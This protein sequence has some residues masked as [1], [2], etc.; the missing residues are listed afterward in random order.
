M[1]CPRCSSVMG[2]KTTH[3]LRNTSSAILLPFTGGL[4]LLGFRVERYVCPRCGSTVR[5][6][7]EPG[8]RIAALVFTGLA[9][10]ILLAQHL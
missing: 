2:V 10:V 3:R 4:S 7:T 8:V 1:V 5:R 6:R 9:V